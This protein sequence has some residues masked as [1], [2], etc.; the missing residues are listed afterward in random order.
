MEPMPLR[1]KWLK[2]IDLVKYYSP[3][4]GFGAA[5]P[6]GNIEAVTGCSIGDAAHHQP[7]FAT[8]V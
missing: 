6:R 4:L 2:S 1:G 7:I 8:I 5:N 3:A